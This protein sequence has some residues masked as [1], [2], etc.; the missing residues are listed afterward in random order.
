MERYLCPLRSEYFRRGQ[1]ASAHF[2][3][4]PRP[5]GGRGFSARVPR[6]S[7]RVVPPAV[8]S[9]LGPA[10]PLLQFRPARKIGR[11][12]PG[13]PPGNPKSKSSHPYPA[14]AEPS[15]REGRRKADAPPPAASRKY[16]IIVGGRRPNMLFSPPLLSSHSPTP[17]PRS[18]ARPFSR[19]T[20]A[21]LRQL[22]PRHRRHLRRLTL[23]RSLVF[24]LG[25]AD[26]P[27]TPSSIDGFRVGARAPSLRKIHLLEFRV[28]D[29]SSAS[30]SLSLFRSLPRSR[31]SISVVVK[32]AKN[33]K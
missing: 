17:S 20:A 28:F 24:C 29:R 2:S 7:P 27:L 10:W 3:L 30:L 4:P 25:S 1:I 11:Q 13:N 9:S 5:A 22:I 23:L 8:S 31:I 14:A 6:T 18:L 12:E 21:P 26:G 32:W 16:D 33:R 15:P 19:F